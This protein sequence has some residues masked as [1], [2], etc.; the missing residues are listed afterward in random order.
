MSAD[1]ANVP[2]QN[3][4]LEEI[5]KLAYKKGFEYEQKY[6]QCSQCCAAAIV[7]IFDLDPMLI[8]SGYLLSGGFA[9]CG[10]GTCGALSGAAM[11]IS[12]LYGRSREEFADF[13]DSRALNMMLSIQKKFEEKFKSIT[14]RDVQK[15]IFGRSYNFFSEADLEQFEKDGGHE[16]KCPDVVGSTAMWLAEELWKE[17]NNYETKR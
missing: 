10:R 15:T 4:T 5:T 9:Q 14:C 3:M 17:E 11:I 16:D 2:A 13:N 6:G 8:K 7:D 12:S 1:S